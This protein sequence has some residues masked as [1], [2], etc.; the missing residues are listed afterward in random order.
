M[1]TFSASVTGTIVVDTDQK[2]DAEVLMES[3]LRDIRS[4]LAER[5]SIKMSSVS[6]L[7]IEEMIDRIP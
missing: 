7:E 5:G 4:A 2:C 6:V 1:K 3:I